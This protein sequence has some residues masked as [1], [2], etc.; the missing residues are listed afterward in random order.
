[1]LGIVDLWAGELSWDKLDPTWKKTLSYEDLEKK[2][3]FSSK[4]KDKTLISSY[5]ILI[6]KR[7]FRKCYFQWHSYVPLGIQPSQLWQFYYWAWRYGLQCILL[8]IKEI[9]LNFQHRK[10]MNQTTFVC[11]K[12]K[13]ETPHM[14]IVTYSAPLQSIRRNLYKVHCLFSISFLNWIPQ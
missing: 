1:M 7:N 6:F 14:P 4:Y 3:I 13:F 5:P 2:L 10:Y 9:Y 12:G 8:K 11:L